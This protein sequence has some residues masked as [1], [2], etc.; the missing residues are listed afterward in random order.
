MSQSKLLVAIYRTYFIITPML[1]TNGHSMFIFA[2]LRKEV[3]GV[4]IV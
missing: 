2:T 3:R 1:Q 4:P